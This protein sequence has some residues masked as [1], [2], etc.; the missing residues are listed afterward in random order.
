MRRL[1]TLLAGLALAASTVTAANAVTI[2]RIFQFQEVDIPP[3]LGVGVEDTSRLLPARRATE[4][5]FL[6][7]DPF[8]TSLGDLV[9]VQIDGSI[10]FS[11]GG[12]VVG[13]D[14]SGFSP[15]SRGSGTYAGSVKLA[16]LSQE[17]GFGSFSGT[18]DCFGQSFL[19]PCQGFSNTIESVGGTIQFTP[20]EWSGI[21]NAPIR[22]TFA[23]EADLIQGQSMSGGIVERSESNRFGINQS[24]LRV[25]YTY[26]R[27]VVTPPP[28]VAAVPLPASAALL[29]TAVV[30]MA[31]VNRRRKA[32]A[33]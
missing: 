26:D 25:I 24:R 13:S 4:T 15:T 6:G 14:P 11:L 1:A 10:R 8:D 20:D 21:N 29:L 12:R 33:E 16:I 23:A 2:Q 19:N 31:L 32:G 28:P 27:T 3:N 9:S 17:F 18:A 5:V 22:V 30:G 7:Y